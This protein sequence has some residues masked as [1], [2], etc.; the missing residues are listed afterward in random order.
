MSK[1]KMSDRR[2]KMK[3]QDG[4]TLVE[5]L[6]AI[7]I[8][9]VVVAVAVPQFSQFKNRANDA[10]TQGTLRT[11]YTACQDFW[12]FYSS[13]TP[14]LLTNISNSEHGYIPSAVVEVAIDSNANNTEYDFVA[15]AIHTSSSNVF[16]IDY[17]GIVSKASGGVGLNGGNNG[18]GCSEEAQD[19]DPQNLGQNA[20]GGCGTVG[21][22]IGHN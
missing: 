22:N 19:N 4:F 7:F 16:V 14:C 1:N 10:S 3:R 21:K 9:A 11:V 15:T 2:G 12:T 13:N 5:L 20:A 17:R 18:H 8:I 6:V